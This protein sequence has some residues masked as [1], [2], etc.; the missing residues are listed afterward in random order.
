MRS[1]G[2]GAQQIA[3]IVV[4]WWGILIP[5]VDAVLARTLCV[6]FGASAPRFFRYSCC[7]PANLLSAWL[8]R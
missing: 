7:L 6:A 1:G 8:L 5:L 3:Q 2:V 4:K